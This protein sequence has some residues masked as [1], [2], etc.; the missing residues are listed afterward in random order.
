MIYGL[1]RYNKTV[2]SKIMNKSVLLLAALF[3]QLAIA[4]R[5]T[6]GMVGE[7]ADKMLITGERYVVPG[8]RK[9]I[10]MDTK[11]YSNLTWLKI[12]GVATVT[13]VL[14]GNAASHVFDG[15]FTYY[16]GKGDL[17]EMVTLMPNTEVTLQSKELTESMPV[18]EYNWIN[19]EGVACGE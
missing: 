2:M 13:S 7:I 17:Y 16:T 4:D 6:A 3:S 10:I 9:L 1:S 12:K 15:S 5:N 11:K 19:K 8:C 18:R 14:N